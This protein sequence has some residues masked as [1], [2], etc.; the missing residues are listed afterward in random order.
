MVRLSPFRVPTFAGVKRAKGT[1]PGDWIRIE[2][3]AE[4]F[5]VTEMEAGTPGAG[6]AIDAPSV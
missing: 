2:D 3:G 1:Y 4:Y 6:I 5:R